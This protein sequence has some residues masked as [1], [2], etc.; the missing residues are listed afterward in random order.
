MELHPAQ[1]F[2][3]VIAQQEKHQ[4]RH[5]QRQQ[6]P[7][8]QR[9]TIAHAEDEVV[10]SWSNRHVYRVHVWQVGFFDVDV[11]AVRQYVSDISHGTGPVR[12]RRS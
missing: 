3:H 9:H 10:N 4:D 11:Q 6:N 2:D 12:V 7:Y 1:R 5:W 8:P